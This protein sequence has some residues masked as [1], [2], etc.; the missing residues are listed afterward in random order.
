MGFIHT[1]TFSPTGGT[2]NA[3]HLLAT[4]LA[5]T[6]DPLQEHDVTSAEAQHID[7]DVN[8]EDLAVFSIPS[9]GGQ[10]PNLPDL[11]THVHGNASSAVLFCSFGNRAFEDTL[12]QLQQRITAQGFHV[13][14]AIAVVTPHVCSEKAGHGRP[15]AVDREAIHAFAQKVRTIWRKR[16]TA[17]LTLPGHAQRQS[18]PIVTAHKIYR[19]EACTHCGS[20]VNAC[21]VRA[22]DAQT[23]DID[24]TLCL[25][26]QRCTFVCHFGARTYDVSHM[27]PFLETLF[28]ERK[29]IVTFLPAR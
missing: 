9:Y 17:T 28:Y 5:A 4:A 29:K 16:E 13:I 18:K 22:I 20:C 8:A 19:A 21:P 15:D 24:E 26:C 2:A 6:T 25:G 1:F 23:L 12:A 14:G 3:A 10:M 11:F 27:R 7:Y